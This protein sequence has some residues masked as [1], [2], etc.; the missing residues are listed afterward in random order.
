MAVV[1]VFQTSTRIGNAYGGWAGRRAGWV[2]GRADRWAGGG[3][4]RWI[5]LCM[6]GCGHMGWGGVGWAG[7][8]GAG[9]PPR[10]RQIGPEL[11]TQ[12]VLA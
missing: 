9:V 8:G 11:R 5:V 3:Q 6:E 10:R 4:R 2:G 1:L 12:L 7:I